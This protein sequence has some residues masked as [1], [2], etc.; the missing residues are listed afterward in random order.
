MTEQLLPGPPS[1]GL[2]GEYF[3]WHDKEELRIQRCSDCER[4]IHPPQWLCPTCGSRTLEWIRTSGRGT[5]FTWTR[6]H[7][8]FNPEFSTEPPYICAVVQLEEGPKI[9]TSLVGAED[10]ALAIGMPVVIEFETRQEAK[11]AVFVPQ[12]Q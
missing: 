5:L 3:A 7:Y 1:D 6:T 10:A 8:Q 9:L 11:V 2:A 4:W 12:D